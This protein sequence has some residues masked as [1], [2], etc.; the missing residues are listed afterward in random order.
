VATTPP[1]ILQDPN[2]KKYVGP[3]ATL[4]TEI[5]AKIGVK[6]KWVPET[7][8]TIIAALQANQIDL[9][10]APLYATPERLKVID[11]SAWAKDG[12]CYLTKKS[13]S[14]TSL[15]QLNS[16]DVSMG[17]ITGTGTFTAT[18]GKYPKAKQVKRVASPGEQALIPELIS[19]RV[20]VD[21]VDATLVGV[22]LDKYPELRVVPEGC[23][24]T[25]NP[26]I[27]TPIAVGYRKGDAAFG[28]FVA[29]VI[30]TNRTKLQAEVEQFSAPTY[31]K[32]GIGG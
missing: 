26:D 3:G 29:Q 30:A 10:D 23:S 14:I 8:D 31:M 6:V 19:G 9:A 7:Y 20:D 17:N 12:F 1:F 11:M 25:S 28:K 13:S 2:T 21:P 4:A 18:A 27:P 32:A 5:A 22:Y 15:D 24:A 16:S